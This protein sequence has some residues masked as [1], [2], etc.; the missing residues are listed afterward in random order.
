MRRT[1]GI[2][3]GLLQTPKS[4]M[5]DNLGSA[6]PDERG[7]LH[8]KTGSDFG[9]NLADQIKM[10]PTPRAQE[11]GATT[12]GYG[13]SLSE[14][15]E[16]REQLLPTP[17]TQETEHP[18]AELT[19]TGRRKAA[20]GNSHSMGLADKVAMLPTPRA[21][22]GNM[23]EMGSKGMEHNAKKNY[24]DGTLGMKT[25]LKLQPGFALWMMGYQEDWC[26][27]KDG[28]MP[29]SKVRGTH[30]SPK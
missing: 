20:N 14:T 26:D 24:L 12:V 17:T 5:P 30:G 28:E 23:G 21:R 13:K 1:E 15:V 10:L 27:L 3:S 2:G 9:M 29:P 25:G 19:K 22:E 8:R 4:V 16:G 6:V 11:P 7:R 18:Q